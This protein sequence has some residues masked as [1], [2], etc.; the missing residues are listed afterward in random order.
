VEYWN[1]GR[2]EEKTVDKE[3][4]DRRKAKNRKDGMLE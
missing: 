2:M 3:T 4:V 1:D